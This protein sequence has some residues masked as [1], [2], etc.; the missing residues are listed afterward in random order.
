MLNIS[1]GMYVKLGKLKT[2]SVENSFP[3]ITARIRRMRK[4]IVS[5]C[6][7]VHTAGGGGGKVTPST[8]WGGPPSDPNRGIPNPSQWEGGGTLSQVTMG[9]GTPIPGQDWG[10]GGGTP[11]W[12]SI[13]CTCYAVGS[14]PLAFTQE[15]YLVILCNYV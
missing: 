13:A 5:V 9:R 8:D 6:G 10:K 2:D 11:N 12:N 3:V 7:S 4:V 14:M 15:D 1:P